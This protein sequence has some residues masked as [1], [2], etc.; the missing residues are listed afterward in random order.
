MLQTQVLD[1]GNLTQVEVAVS[2]NIQ[3]P[4]AVVVSSLRPYQEDRFVRIIKT[5][6]KYIA[7]SPFF[8][9]PKRYRCDADCFCVPYPGDLLEIF[10]LHFGYCLSWVA[11]VNNHQVKASEPSCDCPWFVIQLH[12]SSR[13]K[14]SC[15]DG[16]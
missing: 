3:E 12:Q 11:Q 2:V 14:F 16:C 15:L 13:W 9:V 4:Q 6:A 1:A 7:A 8:I 10:F 5:I